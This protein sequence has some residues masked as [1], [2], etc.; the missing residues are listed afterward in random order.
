MDDSIHTLE[1]LGEI[2]R[3]DV[4]HIYGFEIGVLGKGLF[5]EGDFRSPS[6]S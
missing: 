2:A 5:E 1:S 6:G 4:R 3:R